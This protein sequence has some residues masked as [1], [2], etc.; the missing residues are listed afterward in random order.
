MDG[1]SRT[2]TDKAGTEFDQERRKTQM[3]L[4]SKKLVRPEI[5]MLKKSV[6]QKIALAKE[7]LRNEFLQG[8]AKNEFFVKGKMTMVDEL[9][10]QLE[11]L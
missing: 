9:I 2:T 8:L 10:E 3:S 6:D 5:E 1:L 11:N 7:E 4:L